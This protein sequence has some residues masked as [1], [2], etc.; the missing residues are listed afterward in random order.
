[1]AEDDL[2]TV[3]DAQVHPCR[4]RDSGSRELAG[5]EHSSEADGE[6]PIGRRPAVVAFHSPRSRAGPV[7]LT[8]RRARV[9]L[10]PGDLDRTTSQPGHEPARRLVIQRQWGIVVGELTT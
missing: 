5:E 6:T 7:F 4:H 10:R 1:V 3:D 2:G 9:A 8:E